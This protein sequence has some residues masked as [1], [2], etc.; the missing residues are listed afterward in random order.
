TGIRIS[1]NGR[2]GTGRTSKGGADKA[3]PCVQEAKAGMKVVTM[4][5][6]FF[7]FLV[8]TLFLAGIT[9]AL[10]QPMRPGDEEQFIAPKPPSPCAIPGG[11]AQEGGVPRFRRRP[12]R[13]GGPE[14]REEQR[15][16][17]ERA[18]DLAQRLLDNP[19]TPD[20]IKARARRL[21]ELLGKRE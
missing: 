18:R 16:R 3:A 15:L 2:L 6:R 13:G 12:G 17:L 21:T 11:G 4:R 5:K 1:T 8:L 9:P 10:A 14:V 20:E 7:S 19:N